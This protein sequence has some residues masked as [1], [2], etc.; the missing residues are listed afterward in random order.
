M[1][2]KYRGRIAEL[3]EAVIRAHK[4]YLRA[5]EDRKA[6]TQDIPSGLP[7]PDGVQRISNAA[8]VE[9]LALGEYLKALRAYNDYADKGRDDPG[10][11]KGSQC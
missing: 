2:S 7:H 3:R 1:D 9:H 4:V 5:A 10:T 6:I 11:A 8:S